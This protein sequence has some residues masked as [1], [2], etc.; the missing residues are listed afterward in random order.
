MGC[1]SSKAVDVEYLNGHPTFEGDEVVKGFEKDNGLLFRI[2]NNKTK[3]WAFYNDTTEYDMHVKVTFNEDCEISA[4]GN[5]QLEQLENNEWVATVVVAP[6][7]TEM[8][9][10]G[11]VNGF[12]SKMD[13]IPIE[14]DQQAPQE[15]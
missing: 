12:K 4:L 7:A 5:T 13:A 3:Q 11:R 6:L 9:I 15:E 8:F 2:V 10:Q 1:G 14:Q